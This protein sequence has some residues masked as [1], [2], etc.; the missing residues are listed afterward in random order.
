MT[1]QT[2]SGVQTWLNG[3]TPAVFSGYVIVAAFSTYFC[4]Y[5]FRKPFAVADFE[6]IVSLG[7]LPDMQLKI[8]LNVSQVIGYCLSKFI[9][10]KVISEMSGRGRAF[11]IIACIGFAEF[12]LFLFGIVPIEWGFL[13][14][15]LNG[16]PLGM[17][18]G[19]VFGFLEG[20]RVSEILGA[21]LSASYILAP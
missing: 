1:T 15:F 16:L 21:G 3:A 17:V 2:R 5:A 20:R 10:I 14:L 9:G 18:W 7:I 13:C 19:L 8:L 4:M 6:Q 12:A 11:A